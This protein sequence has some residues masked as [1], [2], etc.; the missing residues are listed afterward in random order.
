MTRSKLLGWVFVGAVVGAVVGDG[1]IHLSPLVLRTMT[2]LIFTAFLALVVWL[3]VISAYRRGHLSE[4]RLRDATAEPAPMRPFEQAWDAELRH[5][6]FRYVG[7]LEL[8]GPRD[9]PEKYWEYAHEDGRVCADICQRRG[10]A[11]F[12]TTF[13]D[14][15]MLT[16]RNT[17]NVPTV[18]VPFWRAV[19]VPGPGGS[20]TLAYQAHLASLQSFAAA[21]GEAVQGW[22][23][24]MADVLADEERQRAIAPELQ[25]LTRGWTDRLGEIAVLLLVLFAWLFQGWLLIDLL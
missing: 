24:T 9:R 2:W 12:F 25:R 23:Q 22:R 5:L 21:H 18:D 17:A 6:G 15:A 8:T 16:T 13:Q 14:G 11:G 7:V 20:L 10:Y 1:A 4:I 19:N 3:V